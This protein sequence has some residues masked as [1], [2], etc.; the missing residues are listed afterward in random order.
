MNRIARKLVLSIVT[1]VLTVFALGT[2]TFAWFTLTNTAVVQPFQAQIVSDTGIQVALGD[3]AAPAAL[4][5]LEWRTTITTEEIENYIDFKYSGNFE[6]MNV[7]SPDG[8]TMNELGGA[9]APATSYLEINLHFRSTDAT[10]IFWD[11]VE[12]SATTTGWTTGT[13]FFDS[14]GVERLAGSNFNINAADAFRVSIRSN[15]AVPLQTVYENPVSATNTVLGEQIAADFQNGGVGVNGSTNYYY[16]VNQVLPEG[17]DAVSVVAT[18]TAINGQKVLN[19]TDDDSVMEGFRYFG[20][21][22]IRIWVEGWD[23]EAYNAILSEIITARF[24]FTA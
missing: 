14:K 16:E 6:F 8:Y 17:S 12:V 20:S 11:E 10:E 23:A 19:M 18:E 3:I 5:G 1:V 15:E 13:T 24:R 2:T 7:T 9:G 4:A 22:T 21:I